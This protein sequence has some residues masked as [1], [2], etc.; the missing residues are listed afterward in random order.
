MEDDRP[1][2]PIQSGRILRDSPTVPLDVPVRLGY[3]Q[4]VMTI[5]RVILYFL[6]ACAVGALV[7]TMS[8]TWIVGLGAFFLIGVLWGLIEITLAD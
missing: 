2:G 7:G 6:S 3:K 8:P 5:V 1:D 4:V